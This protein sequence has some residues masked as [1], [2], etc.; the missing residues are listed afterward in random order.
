MEQLFSSG[1]I[2]DAVLVLMLLEGL[3]LTLLFRAKRIGIAPK[4]LWINLAAGAALF[5]ALRS[6]LA[7]DHWHVT[8]AFLVAGLLAHAAD[9][10]VR[11]QK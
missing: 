5:L 1:Q 10:A 8:A 4:T 3:A 11:W 6:A 9:L 7:G 2:V